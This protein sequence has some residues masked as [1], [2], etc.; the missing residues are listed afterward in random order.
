M[1]FCL[2]QRCNSHFPRN[3]WEIIEELLERMSARKV[4]D[5]G[6]QRHARSDEYRGTAENFGIRTNYRRS[7]HDAAP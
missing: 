5:K 4:V 7:F 6:L 2:L 3:C 1:R